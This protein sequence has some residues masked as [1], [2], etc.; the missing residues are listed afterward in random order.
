MS[1]F[2]ALAAQM[3][4]GRAKY[5]NGCTAFS[6][7]DEAGEVVHAINK[8]ESVERVRDEILDVAAVAMRLY[9]GEIDREHRVIGLEQVRVKEEEKAPKEE[10]ADLGGDRGAPQEGGGKREG[11]GQDPEAH[12]PEAVRPDAE[13]RLRVFDIAI[14]VARA[15]H[16]PLDA[17]R[18]AEKLA[19]KLDITYVGPKIEAFPPAPG[20]RVTWGTPGRTNREGIVER[21]HGP[22]DADVYRSGHTVRVRWDDGSSGSCEPRHLL[23]VQRASAAGLPKFVRDALV[24]A[25]CK[26]PVSAADRLRADWAAK[27]IPDIQFSPMTGVP[28]LYGPDSAEPCPF[29]RGDEVLLPPH[30]GTP[31][32]VV[33]SVSVRVHVQLPN[34]TISHFAPGELKHVE[35]GRDAPMMDGPSYEAGYQDGLEERPHRFEKTGPVDWTA[36]AHMADDL[37][38]SATD[39]AERLRIIEKCLRWAHNRRVQAAWQP[40]GCFDCSRLGGPCPAHEKATAEKANPTKIEPLHTGPLDALQIVQRDRD[41]WKQRAMQAELRRDG[42]VRPVADPVGAHVPVEGAT[43]SRPITSEGPSEDVLRMV[44]AFSDA[45]RKEEVRKLAARVKA[46]EDE[47]EAFRADMKAAAG[48]LMLPIP[49]PHSAMAKLMSANKMLRDE[50]SRLR[51][52]ARVPKVTW[53]VRIERYSSE[54]EGEDELN[55]SVIYKV[56]FRSGVQAFRIATVEIDEATTEAEAL[57]HCEFHKRMFMVALGNL[58]LD[59]P[60]VATFGRPEPVCPRCNKTTC[61]AARDWHEHCDSDDLK[62]EPG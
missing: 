41:T 23:V 8:Y 53:D 1:A 62:K 21:L 59:L 3:A 11:A 32:G 25:M 5:P 14:H 24:C 43:P 12:L 49:T 39:T 35:G 28:P 15:T 44:H 50:N 17:E 46:N 29:S 42:D 16:S 30:A 34:G 60:P 2:D 45:G 54:E 26:R 7:L 36:K 38:R 4:K 27:G 18:F 37:I 52:A 31:K 10:G 57:E 51:L 58:G 20:D 47:L 56:E 22:E 48:E 9:L 55:P 33:N 6:L 13:C 40:E 19:A 61:P